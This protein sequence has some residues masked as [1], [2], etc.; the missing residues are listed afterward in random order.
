M[1]TNILCLIAFCAS[2]FVTGCTKVEMV[3]AEPE[4]LSKPSA[5]NPIPC[6]A[7]SFISSSIMDPSYSVTGFSKSMDAASG[8][9]QL[10]TAGIYSGGGIED[11]IALRAVYAKQSIAFVHRDRPADTVLVA[12]L[13]K[14]GMVIATRDGNAPDFN[15]L[16]TSFSYRNGKISTMKVALNG[17]SLSSNFSY[18]KNGNI[19]LIQNVSQYGETPGRIE[20]SYDA[21]RKAANQVYFDEPRGFSLNTYTLLEYAGLLPTRPV[22]LRTAVKVMWEDDYEAYNA[23]L[24]NHQVDGSGNLIQ[25]EM[26]NAGGDEVVSRYRINWACGS[27]GDNIIQ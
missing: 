27:G 14:K 9:V 12:S 10:I 3:N 11:S 23:S 17:T 19:T 1:K 7:L 26:K 15:F 16:P 13:D 4:T 24:L 18:D 2:V 25:Y 5:S 6:Q 22:N 21:S 8:Q 20:Y